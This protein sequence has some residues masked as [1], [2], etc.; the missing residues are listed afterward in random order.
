MAFLRSAFTSLMILAALG[1]AGWA[2]A[3]QGGR[4]SVRLDVL[5]H[6]AP[7]MLALG[8][9]PLVYALVF[10]R[11]R[12][13]AMLLSI[14]AV[15]VVASGLLVLPEY[16]RP[17]SELVP[18]GRPG[19][20]KLIQFN[21]WERNSRQGET[22]R[23]LRAQNPD[24]LVVE[25]ASLIAPALRRAFDGYY[26]SCGHCSVMI[27]S[28][29]KPVAHDVPVP[30][31]ADDV[32]PPIAGA[33]FRDAHGEFSV[34]G[35]HYTWP[36]YG[37]WQQAQGRVI[38]GLLHK[39]PKD[40]LILS[41]DFNSTPWSFSRRREDKMFGLERR[42]RALFSWPADRGPGGT[43]LP[44]GLLPI[45]HVY[46]G[47]GWRTVKTERGPLLGSDHYPVIVTLAPSA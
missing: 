47:P 3:A 39:F 2:L 4:W 27:L 14:S 16:L 35:T 11:G 38:A 37:G 45:D 31:G 46:A 44:F 34:F 41:G 32:R 30:P 18:A 13:Q 5:T 42:T 17:R 15:G 22:I 1:C 19:Q 43:G 21:A 25:E 7:I 10:E 29:A 20:I 36:I 6:F 33:T 12:T 40:R 23:W 8:L 26:V 9:A 28:K 24:I